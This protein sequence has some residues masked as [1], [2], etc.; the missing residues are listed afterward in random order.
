M[1]FD[2]VVEV[3][4]GLL[5]SH[6]RASPGFLTVFRCFPKHGPMLPLVTVNSP[7]RALDCYT[8]TVTDRLSNKMSRRE[9]D[10]MQ[11]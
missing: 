2:T 6:F 7:A 5:R 10:Q 8:M 3:K 11:D 1:T 4:P 9:T